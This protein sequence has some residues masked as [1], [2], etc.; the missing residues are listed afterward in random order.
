[1]TRPARPT[2]VLVMAHGTP[3]T[4]EAIEPFYTAIRRGRPPSPELLAELTGRYR[5]IGGTSPLTE[6]TAAQVAGV[7]SALEARSPG[8]Y[9]VGYGAK[10]VEPS[11]ET[12]MAALAASGVDRV[13]GIVL[14]P[15]ASASGSGEYLRRAAAAAAAADSHPVFVP[16]R[17]WHRAP[18]FAPLLAERTEAAL[19][20]LPEGRRSP[21]AVFFTA[22]S[23]PLRALADDDSYPAQVGESASDIAAILDLDDRP[24]L[25]WSV[26]W[27]SAGRTPDPWLGPDLV[28]EIS[29]VAE[30]GVSSVVVCP[31]GFVSDH[32]EVLYDLDIEAAGAAEAAGLAFTRT[33]SLDDDPR[34]VAIL[35][36][37]VC[38]A[39]A[40]GEL[41]GV[42]VS[43]A[44]PGRAPAPGSAPA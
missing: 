36:D 33:R 27:Q 19:T 34:F 22:H 6:R 38:A 26:A 17:S 3:A 29:R 12:G 35:A 16:V 1:M 42:P 23:L 4:P 11:I 44:R 24:G 20:A 15:H 28:A 41:P 37:V 13:V 7:A 39:A 10:F 30:A 18:G 8:G 32:L 14:T 25:T 5:A 43:A 2:G 31:A 9:T 21:T 40:G